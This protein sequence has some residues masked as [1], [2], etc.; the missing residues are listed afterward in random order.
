[1]D[2]CP[3]HDQR[4]PFRVTPVELIKEDGAALPRNWELLGVELRVPD[5]KIVFRGAFEPND[6]SQSTPLAF[7]N[8]LDPWSTTGSQIVRQ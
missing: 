2:L 8:V 6:K 4:E 3:G 7:S 1:M 5:G